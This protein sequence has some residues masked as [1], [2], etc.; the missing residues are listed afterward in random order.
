MAWRCDAQSIR[1]GTIISCF[2]S[3]APCTL[4]L[5]SCR[6][7]LFFTTLP[8]TTH[9]YF[10]NGNS[11]G[12]DAMHPAANKAS[13]SSSISSTAASAAAAAATGVLGHQ[14]LNLN[15]RA[16]VAAHPRRVEFATAAADRYVSLHVHCAI[17]TADMPEY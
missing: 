5:S 14:W 6:S 9:A 15:G 4:V 10:D 12:R 8:A 2:Y 11:R 7:L 16:A 17:D 1:V 3:T 13:R